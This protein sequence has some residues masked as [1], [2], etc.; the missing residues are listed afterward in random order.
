[1]MQIDTEEY[2]AR[3][4][5]VVLLDVR[6]PAEY[7]KGH[8]PGAINMPL[9][10]DEERVIVGTTYKQKSPEKAL[11]VG[12]EMVGPKM[13]TM[14]ED[15]KRYAGDKPLVVHC[16][17][18]GKRSG[19]VGWLLS[20]AGMD[21]QTLK[22][23]YK[24]YRQY[25]HQSLGNLP[26]QLIKL[27]GHTGSRKTEIL[28]ALQDLGEQIVD[29]EGLANHKGSAFGAMGLGPQPTTEQF[30]NDL[31]EVFRGLNPDKHTWI[32][33]ESKSIG[34]VY[35]PDN[36]WHNIMCKIPEIEINVPREIRIK[37]LMKTYGQF[38]IEDLKN[39]FNKIQKRLGGQHHKKAIEALD[40][41]NIVEA[42]G[43]S[44][45]YYDKAYAYSREKHA[46]SNM[47]FLD[48]PDEGI[49]EAAKRILK[50]KKSQELN[51]LRAL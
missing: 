35:L 43:I 9:F 21:V 27:S 1:M 41:G 37:H 17:R 5:K 50:F 34:S 23:G 18:G 33:G 8:I 13:R 28:Y 22:G 24:A 6:T 30:E 14:V 45:V 12:L 25:V 16:W 36:F 42:A 10:S 20:M 38:P 11:L 29:L 39:S 15:A 4:G 26:H 2:F 46:R 40:N 49:E 3:K 48:V 47:R 32:E 19:S 44:L 31:W 51:S 7:Q